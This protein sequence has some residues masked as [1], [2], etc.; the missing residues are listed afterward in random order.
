MAKNNPTFRF[1]GERTFTVLATYPGQKP[2]PYAKVTLTDRFQAVQESLTEFESDALAKL[3]RKMRVTLQSRANYQRWWMTPEVI[4][5]K[6][7]RY[8]CK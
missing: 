6:F 1:D 4:C 7:Y 3:T 5:E 8:L 2:L